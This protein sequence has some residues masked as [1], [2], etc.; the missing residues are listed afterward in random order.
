MLLEIIIPL[1]LGIIAGTITGL[2]P[3]VHINLVAVLLLTLSTK[4]NLPIFSIVVFIIS[5]ATTHTFLDFIPSVF[6]G[7]PDPSTVLTVLPGHRYLIKGKGFEAV[8]LSIYGSITGLLLVIFLTPILLLVTPKFFTIIQGAILA[9]IIGSVIFVISKEKSKLKALIIFLMAGC[10]G[11]A[12]LNLNLKQSLFPLLSG[13]FG[14]SGLILSLKQKTILP[15]QK[16]SYPK[17]SLKKSGKYLSS[18]LAA[19]GLTGFLP[20]L[21]AAQAAI[22]GSSF[23][24]KV[25]QS[26]FIFLTGAIN[27]IVM[28]IGLIALMAID[29]TRNGAVVVIK[30]L[31]PTLSLPEFTVLIATSLIAGSISCLL[32]VF[33]AKK[34]SRIIEKVNYK[35]L[36]LA[37]IIFITIL[38]FLLSGFLGLLVLTVATFVGILPSLIGVQ[39]NN[40]MGCLL[41]PVILFFIFAS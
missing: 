31:M 6:L 37:I 35:R 29:K 7:A 40:L 25:K 16:I 41:L 26:D 34:S 13:L 3:G 33:L 18:A 19:G 4:I 20:G 27:T 10:L 12:A 28:I 17:F 30:K 9:I 24:K 1:L 11:I 2:T 8:M 5:M 15:K 22:I 39:K 21:G 36:C 38:A 32:A 23:F 14:T